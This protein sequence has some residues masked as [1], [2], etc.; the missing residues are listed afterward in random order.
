[1]ARYEKHGRALSELG[2]DV[3]PLKGKIPILTGWQ[4]RPDTALDFTK[5]KSA[6]IGLVTGGKYNVV[7]VDID[8]KHQGAVNIIRTLTDDLLGSA[9]ERIGNAPKTMFV[10][11]C[12]EPFKKVKNPIH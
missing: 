9:P 1:M 10:F 8:V 11:R 2:Y 3:T 6:N 5:H 7:A 12:S 4:T